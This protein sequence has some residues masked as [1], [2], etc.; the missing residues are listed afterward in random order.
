MA[1]QPATAEETNY[2][3]IVDEA[4]VKK[5]EENN[6]LNKESPSTAIIFCMDTDDLLPGQKVNYFKRVM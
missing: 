3:L 1:E 4:E 2:A 5:E 6:E